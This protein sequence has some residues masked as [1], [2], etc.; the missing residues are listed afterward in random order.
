MSTIYNSLNKEFKQPIG[1][2]KK[3]ESLKLR[4]KLKKYLNPCNVQVVIHEYCSNFHYKTILMDVEKTDEKHVYFKV[5]IPNLEINIYYYY[6]T[7][8]TNG[9][10]RFLKMCNDSW[11]ACIS[12]S[13][14]SFN[15]QLTVYEPIKTHANM[16]NGIM[17][18]IFPDRFYSSRKNKN[19]PPGRIYRNWGELPFYSDDKICT[20][21]FCG[22]L[23][24]IIE[25]IKYLRQLNISVLYLNPIWE[26]QSNHRYDTASYERVDPILGNMEDLKELIEI[27]HSNGMIIILDTV[28]NH[29]GSDSA[30]FN[31]YNRYPVVGAYNSPN[32]L[33][34]SWYYFH[35]NNHDSYESWWGFNTLPK[36]NQNDPG[37]INYV[38]GEGGIIDK[39]YALGIDGLRLD[40]AD[41]LENSTLA[42]I[43]EA[44]KRN[45]DSIVII[46][47]VWDNA[48]NKCNYGHKMNYFLGNELTSVMNY[49]VKDAV[50]SYIRYGENY[51]QDLKRTLISI[52]IEDYP[53][54]VSHSLM[55]FL[56][57]HDTVRAITKLAGIELGDNQSNKVW[58][59]NNDIL[60]KEEFKLGKLRL[61][62]SYMLIFF[63][64]GIPSV[65]YGDEIGLN[66]YKDPFC[67]K[68]FTWDKIDKKLLMFFRNL[69]KVRKQYSDFLSKSD[70][71]VCDIDDKKCIFMRTFENK[72]LI[73]FINRTDSKVDITDD[74]FDLC[75]INKSSKKLVKCSFDVNILFS[76]G[77]NSD[78]TSLD[79][80]G[81]ILIEVVQTE[82]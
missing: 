19:L 42:R 57:S 81:A 36:L 82:K 27:A 28:L 25:K 21:F 17:Y 80:F 33:F 4:I 10:L 69:S 40:V 24:G 20:D 26:A 23:Q 32:S 30:Y 79:P 77:K 44:S 18:Q 75:F 8:M 9:K 65:Y 51:A 5:E 35:N 12:E 47:E 74:S 58:Q 73:V 2:V 68:C 1:P 6:F 54:E 15:W 48:S 66:G 39:W 76:I 67:R 46:G 61:M 7:F 60:S 41:E 53:K 16:S 62:I 37:F 49:P 71:H 43:N 3:N 56:S 50:L 22:N 38:F 55:N 13:C 63:L 29:T 78:M 52:F 59:S 72:S 11:N 70:F 45:K 14:N 34:Y 31:K 64:P